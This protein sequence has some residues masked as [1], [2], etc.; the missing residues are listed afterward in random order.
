MFTPKSATTINEVVQQAVDLVSENGKEY[1]S[2]ELSMNKGNFIKEVFNSTLVW[3]SPRNRFYTNVNTPFRIG[4]AVARFFYLLSGSNHVAP[5]GFYSPS[6]SHFSDDGITIPGSSYGHRIFGSNKDGGQFEKIAQI[7]MQRPDT[8][9]AEIAVYQPEDAGRESKDIPC[10]S[11]LT[12][13]QRGTTLHM[14]V[15]MRANDVAKLMPYNLFE[16]SLLMECMAARTQMRLGELHHTAVSLHLRGQDIAGKFDFNQSVSLP[17]LP[18]TTFSNQL[19]LKLV[20]YEHLLRTQIAH[21][22]INTGLNWF[23]TVTDVEDAWKDL[24]GILLME[25]FRCTQCEKSQIL[26]LKECIKEVLPGAVLIPTYN[27]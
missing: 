24:L 5:I 9:R 13:M 16:L 19:R 23:I 1:F 7:I 2:S 3:I 15:Q 20:A 12:F 14:T 6:V 11:S 4:L 17:T 22:G 8:K 10:L 27:L 21:Q 25:S 18:I 26:E